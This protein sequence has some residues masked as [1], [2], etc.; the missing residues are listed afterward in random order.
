M[1]VVSEQT[2]QHCDRGA[3]HQQVVE[4][5]EFESLAIEF[6][7]RRVRGWLP[8]WQEAQFL[9]AWLSSAIGS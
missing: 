2:V 5:C 1:S 4:F 7:W 6:S 3:L 9:R 8:A